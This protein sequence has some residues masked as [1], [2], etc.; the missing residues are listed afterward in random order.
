MFIL[1]IVQVQFIPPG[2]GDPVEEALA[3]RR[4]RERQTPQGQVPSATQPSG[5][6]EQKNHLRNAA[7]LTQGTK[8]VRV[9][10]DGFTSAKVATHSG[11]VATHSSAIVGATEHIAGVSSQITALNTTGDVFVAGDGVVQASSTARAAQAFDSTTAT[12]K[13]GETIGTV[14]RTVAK[15]IGRTADTTL[16]RSNLVA[17]VMNGATS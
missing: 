8:L 3:Q 11:K 7:N 9:V 12:L 4:E 2:M 15:T 5:P 16:K 10:K 6:P 13:T 14:N 1:Q 17:K